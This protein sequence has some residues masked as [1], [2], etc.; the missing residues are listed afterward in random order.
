MRYPARDSRARGFTLLELLTVLAIIS[1][2][3][4]FALP[5]YQ[6]YVTRAKIAEGI[7]MLGALKTALT[8]QYYLDSSFPDSNAAAGIGDAAEYRSGS[9]SSVTVLSG[10]VIEL[11][12]AL[13]QLGSATGLQLAPC[14]DNGLVTWTCRVPDAD[15]VDPG[16]L[17]ASCRATAS[18]SS[19]AASDAAVAAVASTTGGAGGTGSGAASG[20][21]RAAASAAAASVT[22]TGTG[23][24]G[25]AYGVGNGITRG[26]GNGNS[27]A[28]RA[29]AGG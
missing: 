3:A 4:V 1:I 9:V 10:G 14:V 6:R 24:S 7:G 22:G 27:Q 13:P 28:A 11:R 5:A 25:N 2:L 12:Y 15:G 20:A 18:A 16:L 23:N 17:P 19:C 29:A 8:E 21:A 26:S